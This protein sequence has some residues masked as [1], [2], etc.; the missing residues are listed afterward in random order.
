MNTRKIRT[1]LFALLATAVSA[2]GISACDTGTQPGDTN[3]E[4][5]D[6]H[7]EGSM[8]DGGAKDQ[9]EA[10]RD[11]ME[12]HYER[13]EEGSAVHAGNGKGE[14]TDREGVKKKDQ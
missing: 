7:E 4:R 13:T 10:E 12:Q 3:V 11:S 8:V 2:F 14:G 9:N 6:H 5:S 1:A